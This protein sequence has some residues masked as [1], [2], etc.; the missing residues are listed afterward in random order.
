PRRMPDL[1]AGSQLVILG[2]YTGEGDAA[3]TLAGRVNGKT[4]SFTY[5]GKFAAAESKSAFIELLWAQRRIGDLLDQIR[6]Q[7]ESKEL[8]DDVIRLS[9]EYGIQTPYTSTLI[10]EGQQ[11]LG[12]A[13]DRLR[14]GRNVSSGGAAGKPAVE[15]KLAQFAEPAKAPAA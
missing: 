2:R 6:M 15:S 7:G 9:K 14:R 12:A 1:Y 5:E 3:L 11:Q 13:D 8:I 4:E 10:L